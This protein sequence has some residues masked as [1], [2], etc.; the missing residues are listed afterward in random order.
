[1]DAV[2][3]FAV[4]TSN[5]AAE[6]GQAGGGLFNM[7]MKSGTNKLHGSA[8]DYWYNE[9]FNASSPYGK[10][11][12]QRRHDYGFTLG[13]PVYIPKVYDGRDK[14]FFFFNF[15]QFRETSVDNTTTY[16][17]P[18]LKMRQ[19]D[20]SEVLTGATVTTADG[21]TTIHKTSST[22]PGRNIRI[23]G[24]TEKVT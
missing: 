12:R 8:Y 6:Y 22:N 17:V 2:E 10:K 20:F 11:D 7:T 5:F 15:E 9:A 18:T 21:V 16:T 4:Q 1:M 23:S 3:E 19:G 13:G 14:T 24:L